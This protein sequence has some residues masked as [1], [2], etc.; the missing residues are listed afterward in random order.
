LFGHV[1]VR[2]A[3]IIEITETA[4]TLKMKILFWTL[5]VLC[6]TVLSSSFS[7]VRLFPSRIPTTT[8]LQI[9]GFGFHARISPQF[10][11][12]HKR[13]TPL[14]AFSSDLSQD[15]SGGPELDVVAKV[16]PEEHS[17]SNSIDAKSQ[18]LQFNLLA[19]CAGLDR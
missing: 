14:D 7:I 5:C 13:K 15:Y 17:N 19:A 10:N 18:E 8:A 9:S 1:A 3:A 6:L 12:L 2:S 11:A 4:Q 16:V